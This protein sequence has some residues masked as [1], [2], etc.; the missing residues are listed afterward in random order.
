MGI[1]RKCESALVGLRKEWE[2]RLKSKEWG[3]GDTK[4]KDNREEKEGVLAW[5][6]CGKGV[7]KE[8]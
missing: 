2:V 1:G 7:K 4:V 3:D 5:E 6:R 8:R